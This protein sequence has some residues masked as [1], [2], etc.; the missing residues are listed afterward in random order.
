MKNILLIR[1]TL[2]TIFLNSSIFA[3]ETKIPDWKPPAARTKAI[4]LFA[5]KPFNYNNIFK[6]DAE[7]WLV[8]SIIK[9]ESVSL[10]ISEDKE[11]NNYINTLG[12]YLVKFSEAPNKKFQFA[13][14]DSSEDNAFNLGG[15]R[16]FICRGLLEEVKNED[17][18]A[19]IIGHEIGHDTFQ[20]I[21]K[22][23]TRQLFWMNGT[24]KIKTAEEAA[25]AL[26]ALLAKYAEN[27][28]SMLIEALAS[29]PKYSKLKLI[30]LVFT[31]HIKRVT[32][33]LQLKIFLSDPN[34]V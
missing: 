6:G 14:T 16:I 5:P 24:T 26:K 25:K 34:N 15:G 18:L 22:T 12:N 32:T 8:N 27:P 2:L 23:V 33:Q 9:L 4:T 17:E 31:S 28:A 21:P 1:L 10:A 7:Q 3:Q 20:H 11:V 13:V 19:A 29:F 30:V